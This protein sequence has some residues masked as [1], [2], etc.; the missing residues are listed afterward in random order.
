[1]MTGLLIFARR[2]TRTVLRFALLLAVMLCFPGNPL[3]AYAGEVIRVGGTGCALGG[4]KEAAHVFRKKRP[5]VTFSFVPSLGSSGGIK[6]VLSGALDLSL[7]SR[8]ITDEERK[9]GASQA[10]YARTP[11]IF[12]TS[13]KGKTGDVTL[14]LLVS[15]YAGETKTWPDGVPLRLIMRPAGDADMVYLK[16]LS[17]AMDKAVAAALKREGMV[18]AVTDQENADAIERIRGGFGAFTLAQLLAEQR[19]L[20]PL[21]LNGTT[22]SLAAL[23]NGSYPYYKTFYAVT[24]SRPNQGVQAFIKFL[25]SPEGRRVLKETGHLAPRSPQ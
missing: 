4:M 5:D 10:E 1:M 2:S 20:T 7:S 15:I 3:A 8:P 9:Q 23:S 11:F 17:P 22:P 12:V 21:R 14:D 16:T 18:M 6:A 13:H 19:P 24:V 25:N